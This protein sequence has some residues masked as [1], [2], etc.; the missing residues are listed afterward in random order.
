MGVFFLLFRRNSQ[1]EDI[2]T[3][4]NKLLKDMDSGEHGSGCGFI[5]MASLIKTPDSI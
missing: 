1:S 2:A 3:E 5:S 4:V